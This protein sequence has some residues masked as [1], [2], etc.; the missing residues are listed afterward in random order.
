MRETNPNSN[1]DIKNE[2]NEI[3]MPTATQ[4]WDLIWFKGLSVAI[5]RGHERVEN[6]RK[7]EKTNDI[8][9]FDYFKIIGKSKRKSKHYWHYIVWLF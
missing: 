6:K 2:E 8:I 1:L 7:L 4:K 3:E 9:L 5:E